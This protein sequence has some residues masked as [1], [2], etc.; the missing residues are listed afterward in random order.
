MNWG[1]DHIVMVLG[2]M[3]GALILWAILCRKSL[4]R[5]RVTIADVMA[6]I[7]MIG[8]VLGIISWL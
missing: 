4:A 2:T 6:L 7:L 1:E 8:V 5:R 3:P